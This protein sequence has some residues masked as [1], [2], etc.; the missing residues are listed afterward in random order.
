MRSP[1]MLLLGCALFVAGPALAVCVT[2]STSFKTTAFSS[3]GG[4]F[5]VDYTATPNGPAVDALTMLSLGA[6]GS[7]TQGA[8]IVRFSTTGLIDARDGSTYNSSAGVP[9]LQGQTYGFH[10]V[11]KVSSHTYTVDVKLPS[12]Q[13]V[14]LNTNGPFAFRTEQKAVTAL[15]HWTVTATTGTHTVC[16]VVISAP[17]QVGNCDP[18]AHKYPADCTGSECMTLDT[19]PAI[20]AS[21]P[22][23]N[24]GGVVLLTRPSGTSSWTKGATIPVIKKK[25]KNGK[26]LCIVRGLYEPSQLPTDCYAVQSTEIPLTRWLKL[27]PGTMYDVA[28]MA[29]NPSGQYQTPP[30]NYC[31]ADA[32]SCGEGIAP[33]CIAKICWPYVWDIGSGPLPIEQCW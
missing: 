15:D 18:C 4:T 1:R 14:P 30:T 17:P 8:V 2:S 11:V 13:T 21:Y 5:T 12:G 6:P 25:P 19:A 33:G 29:M 20:C 27:Q 23:G 22:Q 9:Y 32:G 7:I 3:Q 31:E 24:V 28:I 10:I 26:N 16:D